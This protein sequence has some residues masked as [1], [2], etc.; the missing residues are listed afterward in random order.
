MTG[1]V[2]Q[3][4]TPQVEYA[5]PAESAKLL[6]QALRARFPACEF[7]VRCSRGTGYGDCSVSWRDGPSVRLVE[8]VIASFEG[9]SFDGMTDMRE[10]RHVLLADGRRTGLRLI[11]HQRTISPALAR[12]AAAQVAA[13]YGLPLPTI[14]EENGSWQVDGDTQWVRSDI[15][16]YWSTLIYRAASNASQYAS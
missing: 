12:K 5:T 7:S 6:K 11:N 14:T 13:F 15:R 1:Q 3:F 4:P 8:Q 2:L 9:E 16:E 10:S